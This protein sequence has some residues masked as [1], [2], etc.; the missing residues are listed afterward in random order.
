MSFKVF[1]RNWWK[2]NPNWPN[3]LEP[4]STATKTTLVKRVETE[5]E[6][7]EICKRYN[8]T[9]EAGRLSRKAE[10]TEN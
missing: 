1:V 5:K 9:H 10:Y 3:G 6:A 4:D 7:R 2:E 8:D